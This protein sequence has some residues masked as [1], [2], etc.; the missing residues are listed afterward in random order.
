MPILQPTAVTFSISNMVE[1]THQHQAMARRMCYGW[2]QHL[3]Q[4]APLLGAAVGPVGVPQQ[5]A[6]ARP[7]Q[8]ASEAPAVCAGLPQLELHASARGWPQ[9]QHRHPRPMAICLAVA[10]EDNVR[11]WQ[12]RLLSCLL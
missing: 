4:E 7:P 5:I 8:G 6:V 11:W 9:D 10:A 2:L 12:P 1:V 3:L